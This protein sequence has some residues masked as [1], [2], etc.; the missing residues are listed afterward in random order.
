MLSQ[1]GDRLAKKRGADSGRVEE[2]ARGGTRPRKSG[3][4]VV[5]E[6]GGA[7]AAQAH[8]EIVDD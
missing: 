4:D 2:C 7:M 8:H 1:G 5:L 6:G 3:H